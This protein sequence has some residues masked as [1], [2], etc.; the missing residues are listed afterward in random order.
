MKKILNL[1]LITS[2]VL[3]VASC[4]KD[5]DIVELQ[6][7]KTNIEVT[8]EK[9]VDVTILS[10]NGGYTAIPVSPETA[11][12][13][14]ISDKTIKIT[15]VKEG[16][17]TITVKDRE[18]KT[19]NITV[20][21]VSK[22]TIPTAAQFVWDAEKIELDKSNNWGTVIYSSNR[23][24]V[25]NLIDKKQFLLSWEGGELSKGDRT[26]K[27]QIVGKDPI[28]NVDIEV[29]KAESNTYY[30]YFENG[31]KTGNIYFTK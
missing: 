11:I 28:I 6:L 15:G 1:L 7:D 12:V 20:S 30:I 31:D 23:L 18:G 17:T 27:L 29:V 22:H 24:A 5:D 10:G 25:T 16:E 26:G 4:K 8:E 19:V 3:A 14:D 2:F 9:S 13:A 21:V